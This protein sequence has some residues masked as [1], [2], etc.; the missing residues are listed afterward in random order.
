MPDDPTPH[1]GEAMHPPPD[2]A[3]IPEPKPGARHDG[4]PHAREAGQ[5]RADDAPVTDVSQ[6]P[7]L[8]S[9]PE[10]MAAD[11]EDEE[12]DPVRDTGPGIADD[13]GKPSVTRQPA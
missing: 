8:P 13:S 11:I 5:T 10:R 9:H 4:Q 2:R 6:R 12:A 3:T 1:G 7:P